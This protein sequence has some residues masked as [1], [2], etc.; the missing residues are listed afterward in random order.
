[1]PKSLRYELSFMM[2]FFRNLFAASKRVSSLPRVVLYTRRG[3]HL[4]EVA[5]ATLVQYGQVPK[6]VDID[7]DP[8]LHSRFDRCVPVVEID[9]KIRFRGHV[10]KRLLR[11]LL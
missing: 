11:R 9:G 2:K 10:D 7:E 6:E 3:C 1:M 8:A 5:K 4:C